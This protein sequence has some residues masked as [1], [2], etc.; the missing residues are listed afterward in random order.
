[1]ASEEVVAVYAECLGRPDL[2]DL[3]S[4]IISLGGRASTIDLVRRLFFLGDHEPTDIDVWSSKLPPTRPSGARVLSSRAEI[5]DMINR[6]FQIAIERA[7]DQEPVPVL[8][9][10]MGIRDSFT[11]G[12]WGD[13]GWTEILYRATAARLDITHIATTDIVSPKGRGADMTRLVRLLESPGNYELRVL[14]Q[15][16]EVPHDY[17]VF[18]GLGVLQLFSR[19]GLDFTSAGNFLAE[20]DHNELTA[21]LTDHVRLIR[22]TAQPVVRTYDRSGEKPSLDADTQIEGQLAEAEQRP[23]QR[24]LIKDGLSSLTVPESVATDR[25][26]NSYP[27]EPERQILRNGDRRMA[28]LHAFYGQVNEFDHTDIV[29]ATSLDSYVRTGHYNVDG[30]DFQNEKVMT[31]AQRREHLDHVITLLRVHDRYNLW[32]ADDPGITDLDI[33]GAGWIIKGQERGGQ[34]FF[35]QS[36]K[37]RGDEVISVAGEVSD[38]QAIADLVGEFDELAGRVQERSSKRDVIGRLQQLRDEVPE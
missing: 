26:R 17:V 11:E 23:G 25:L 4:E 18:P 29:T 33:R 20:A 8:V 2:I 24:R 37:R 3:R 15:S 38:D 28:R 12:H 30:D 9:A 21:V 1:M 5:F 6:L 7:G 10:Q 16:S 36:R 27:D 19:D 22:S 35:Y 13:H 14:R 31:P 34:T 32:I